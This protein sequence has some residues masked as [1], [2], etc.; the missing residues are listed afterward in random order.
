MHPIV[1]LATVTVLL[2]GAFFGWL[3]W[4]WS[5]RQ[6]WWLPYLIAALPLSALVNVLVKG[7]IARA[8]QSIPAVDPQ[9][10][11]LPW[12]FYAFALM[13]APLTEEAAKIAPLLLRRLRCPLATPRGAYIAGLA[14]GVGFG[15]GEAVYLA[16]AVAR[17]GSY[18]DV[19]WF[20]FTGFLNERLI[21]VLLHATMVALLLVI[22]QRGRPLLG[23][24]AA[25]G[26]HAV[27][28]GGALL[29]Q[30]GYVSESVA[31]AWLLAVLIGAVALMQGLWRTTA[32]D[33]PY[34]AD[35][36]TERVYW[37]RGA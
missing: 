16:V 27:T 14:L 36:R 1:P 26:L 11:P 12:W 34:P 4:L 37:T 23:Y 22:A 15:I 6:W 29:Y 10:P 9:N 5:R 3:L 24:L 19:P 8:V 17:S 7:P 13:L 20:Q 35:D 28:N 30:L 33:G 21:T 25:V 18:A 2:G 31:N 32:E